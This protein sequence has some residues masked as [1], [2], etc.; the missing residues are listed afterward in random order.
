MNDTEDRARQGDAARQ[1]LEAD[2]ARRTAMIS[3]DVQA[4]GELL[5]EDLIWTHSS[6]KT[7]SRRTFLD[8]IGSGA[9]QYLAL[10]TEDVSVLRRGDVFICHG[11]LN[12]RASRDGV[13]KTL[14]NRFLSVWTADGARPRMIAWQSTSA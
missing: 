9:V 14:T 2:A 11:L 6:G 1:V 5:D 4:L 12:G 7:D 3:G 10:E 8:G 13:E